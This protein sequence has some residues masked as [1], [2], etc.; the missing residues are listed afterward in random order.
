MSTE[1]IA[2]LVILGMCTVASGFFSG[3]ETALI[4]ISRERVHILAEEGPRGRKLKQLVSQPNRMLSTLLVANNAVNVLMASIATILFISL[5][6]DTWGPWVATGTV[7]AVLLVF[8]EITPKTIAALYPERFS[9]RVAPTIWNL[10]IVLAPIAQF[11]S[12]I[13]RGLLRL[14]RLD[15]EGTGNGVTE[16]D[17]RALAALSE[18]GGQ[19]EEV[20]REIIDAVFS[21]ADTSV[22]E[23]MTP[24]L[25]VV[26]LTLPI[27]AADLRQAVTDTGH[28]RFPV[29]EG[30]L[31]D[32]KGMVHVKDLLRLQDH[33]SAGDL[34]RLLRPPMYVPETMSVLD[35]LEMMRAKRH[36]MAVVVDEHG[37]VEGIVTIKDLVS[38]LVGELQDEYDPGTP[39][40]TKIADG[41]WIADGR[42]DMDD[43]CEEIGL[44]KPDGPYSTVG[45][46]ILAIFGKIPSRGDEADA[47]NFNYTVIA[48]DRQRV[49]RVRIQEIG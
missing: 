49:D 19:I 18:R 31:D 47:D 24:R 9:L 39:S 4:S 41:V 5:I 25:D 43:V 36:A 22:R 38:E 42:V 10:S 16:D 1:T 20:E 28:S 48:M 26:S 45:G 35:T 37:G 44:D 7:T 33:E 30:E 32:L 40:I 27:T 21:L 17:I 46:F 14:L 34:A 13:T 12:A 8:G 29:T 2:Y 15:V 11:F 23:V 6:G 3:S